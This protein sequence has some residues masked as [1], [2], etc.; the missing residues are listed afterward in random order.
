MYIVYM[1]TF[2]HSFMPRVFCTPS[3]VYITYYC[4]IVLLLIIFALL[5]ASRDSFKNNFPPRSVSPLY[6]S[7][8][9]RQ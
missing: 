5:P 8:R 3:C 6:R 2:T 9:A 1:Y 4:D 7:R